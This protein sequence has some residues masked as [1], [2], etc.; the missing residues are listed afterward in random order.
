MSNDVGTARLARQIASDGHGTPFKVYTT[1]QTDVT[2]ARDFVGDKLIERDNIVGIIG[3]PGSSK[4]TLG[5]DLAGSIVT[6]RPWF[7]HAVPGG[8]HSAIYLAPERPKETKRRLRAYEAHHMVDASRLGVVSDDLDLAHGEEYARRV[9]ATVLDHEQRTGLRAGVVIIDT[10]FDVLGGGD[11]NHPRDMGGLSR[12]LQQ[13]RRALNVP[14]VV[15]CH[16]SMERV[17]EPRGHKSLLAKMDLTLVVSSDQKTDVR[18]WYVRKANSLEAKP[19][20]SFTCVPV[21][22]DTDTAPVVVAG[23]AQAPA[24]SKEDV[25]SDLIA[26]A[27]NEVVVSHLTRSAAGLEQFRGMG[28]DARRIAVDRVLK[29]MVNA[30]KVEIIGQSKSRRVRLLGCP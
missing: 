14:I 26:V 22:V 20:A 24:G 29:A 27:G 4:S 6:G 8:Q 1:D 2:I 12:N 11:E 30:N 3:P 28:D 19:K 7:G 25:I 17:H 21:L 16:P 18:R 23:G 13:I 5:V 9:V 15:I 10:A